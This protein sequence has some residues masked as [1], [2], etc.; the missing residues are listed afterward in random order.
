MSSNLPALKKA[1]LIKY[2]Q[3]K[4]F[5]KKYK[6]IRTV[7]IQSGCPDKLFYIEIKYNAVIFIFKAIFVFMKH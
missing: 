4:I 5:I 3:N 7:R 6:K 2:H 1:R